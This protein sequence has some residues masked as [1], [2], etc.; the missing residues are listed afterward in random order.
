MHLVAAMKLVNM[1]KRLSLNGAVLL[2]GTDVAP[3]NDSHFHIAT[4]FIAA[5]RCIAHRRW[6]SKFWLPPAAQCSRLLSLT[7]FAPSWRTIHPWVSG[8]NNYALLH[9]HSLNI[10]LPGCILLKWCITDSAFLCKIQ[11]HWTNLNMYNRTGKLA[12]GIIYAWFQF[13]NENLVSNHTH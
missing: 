8:H 7:R 10:V 5:T 6:I 2:L 1:W 9:S 4:S 13:G 11:V 12:T 3:F